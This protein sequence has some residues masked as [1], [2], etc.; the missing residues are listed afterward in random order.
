MADWE[1]VSSLPAGH[2]PLAEQPKPARFCQRNGRLVVHL[3]S[4]LRLIPLLSGKPAERSNGS[5]GIAFATRIGERQDAEV[6]DRTIVPQDRAGGADQSI[7]I[8]AT[9]YGPLVEFDIGIFPVL[10]RGRCVEGVEY[11]AVVFG[12]PPSRRGMACLR[13]RIGRKVEQEV[14]IV[15]SDALVRQP[16][17]QS[18]GARPGRF[19]VDRGGQFG[20]D[21]RLYREVARGI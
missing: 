19:K 18:R 8:E 15:E 12:E 1:S 10:L 16:L 21:R 11:R 2:D 5:T 4:I 6:S 3:A 14:G 17:A 20:R 7:A 13:R 9:E